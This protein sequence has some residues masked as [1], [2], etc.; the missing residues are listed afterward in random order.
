MSCWK[1]SFA[2]PFLLAFRHLCYFFILLLTSGPV[3]ISTS[4]FVLFY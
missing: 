1:P 4:I 2:P 3:F